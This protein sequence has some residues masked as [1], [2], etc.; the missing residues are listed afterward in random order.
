MNGRI[1]LIDDNEDYCRQVQKTLALRDMNVVYFTNG[2]EGLENAL[3]NDWGV[4]LLDVYLNQQIDG[5]E[6]LKRIV[7]KKS[8][9][10]VIM[11]SGASTLQIAVEATKKGAYD[12]LEKPLD[13][14]RLVITINRALEKYSLTQL[15][16]NLLD[17][18]GK[19]LRMVGRSSSLSRILDDVERIARTDSKV[20]ICGESGVGKDIVARLIHYKSRRENRPFVSVNCA[21]IPETLIETELFGYVEGAFTG[22]NQNNRGYIAEAEN[23]TLFLDEIGELPTSAQA[24]L[25]IFLN[26]GS[27]TPVGSTESRQSN[28]RIIAATNKNLENEVKLGNFRE[29]LYYR[30]N[31]FKVH[32]PALRERPEDIEPLALYFLQRACN[33]FGKRITHFSEEAMDI[34]IEQRWQG[35][36]RQLKSAVYRMVLFCNDSMINYGTAAMAIQMDRTNELVSVPGPYQTALEEFEKLYFLNQLNLFGWDLSKVAEAVKL[37]KKDLAKKLEQLG[38]VHDKDRELIAY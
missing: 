17:E 21:A 14:D 1:L 26:D 30:L 34:I 23:G 12:F 29:D 5:L 3:H 10:P 37:P 4:I 27:Y 15:S 32:I 16:Q 11:I 2:A 20:L 18:L 25:L 6:I 31:V 22:A 38:L 13:V 24:K 19:G 36:V 33:K 28:V 35:N 7:E 8:Q 9:I